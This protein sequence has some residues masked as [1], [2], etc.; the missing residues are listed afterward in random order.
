MLTPQAE[1]RVVARPHQG[2]TAVI[3]GAAQGIGRAYAQ[4][5]ATDGAQLILA[6]IGDASGTRDLVQRIGGVAS[7]V[8]C[9]VSDE[10]SVGALA[11]EV[12]AAGGA[13]ILI[14]NAGI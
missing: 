8:S 6:D 9:D 12:A 11:A 3:T 5:L 4:Q 14:H 1:R 10:A 7:V 2:R 13:D